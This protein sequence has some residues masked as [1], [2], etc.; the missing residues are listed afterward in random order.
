[1]DKF[2]AAIIEFLKKET[3]LDKI[4]LEIPPN[5]DMGDY[6]FPCFLLAKELKKSPNEI[7]LELRKKFNP[8][9]EIAQVNVIGPYINFLL[10][11]IE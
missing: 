7:A 1:M 9:G 8:D 10:I 4:E 5:A 6:A 11:K 3:N 2:K